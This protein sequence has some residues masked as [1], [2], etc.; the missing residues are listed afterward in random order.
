MT[1]ARLLAAA[2]LTAS[3][4]VAT[5]ATAAAPDAPTSTYFST[6]N[7]EEHESVGT[8][9]DGDLWPSCWSNDNNLY[10]ANGDGKG[11]TTGG[12]FADVAVNQLRGN[13][14]NLTGDT[15]ARGDAVSQVWS[16]PGYTRKPTG[17]ACVNGTLYL[18]VQDLALDF[19]EVPAATIVKSTDHGRTWTW[20]KTKP[21]FGDHV[22]T[23]IFFADFG[24]DSAWAP[25][26]YVYA[27]GLDNNW[28]DSFDD[29]VPDPATSISRACQKRKS[30]TVPRG[31]SSP[32]RRQTVRHA[33]QRTSASEPPFCT[34][35]AS[36]ISRRFP[37]IRSAISV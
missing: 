26:K 34:T 5:P 31:S 37:P 12:D 7:I 30:R 35:D 16:G 8:T 18:A 27:Y 28:R 17:M 24:K 4:L 29:R 19:N 13:I 3:L 33:G 32:A 36:S 20:D 21:M 2:G 23:T 6:V 22:F 11:F 15:I 9:S 25:D 14:P 10:T 1:L